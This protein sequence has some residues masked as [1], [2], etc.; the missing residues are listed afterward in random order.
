MKFAIVILLGA[1]LVFGLPGMPALY[2]VAGTLAGFAMMLAEVKW[3]NAKPTYIDPVS[4]PKPSTPA[5]A[6]VAAIVVVP[7]CGLLA[8][9]AWTFVLARSPAFGF[10]GIYL[11][12]AGV[13]VAAGMVLTARRISEAHNR[14][15]AAMTPR[16]QLDF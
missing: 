11:A 16:S 3:P 14:W 4:R 2:V 8:F 12:A 5:S 10:F 1:A 6:Y 15:L 7:M 13:G 9:V